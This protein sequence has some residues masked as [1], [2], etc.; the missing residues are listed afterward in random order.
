M[1]S[2]PCGCPGSAMQDFRGK[3]SRKELG[4][5]LD[6]ELRQWPIQLH[7]VG[8][9]APYFDKADLVIAAD[10]VPFAYANFHP[11]FLKDKA[12]VI[13]CPKL[14]EIDS[15]AD[16]I[17]GIIKTGNVKSVTVAHMEVPCCFGLQQIAEEAVKKSGKKIHIEEVTITLQGEKQNA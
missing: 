5:R 13:G 9:G 8:P 4:A 3:K 6:S 11:D 14:D 10:C 12:V 7:L 15:Y 17:A 16:K 1:P 2:M